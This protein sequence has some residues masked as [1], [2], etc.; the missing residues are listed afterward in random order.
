MPFHHAVLA[1]GLHIVG[2]TLPQA[3]SV[4]FGFFVRTGSRDETPEVNGVSHFLEHMVFKGTE[5]FS[6]ED[7]NR[8]FDDV[9]AQY[10]ASTS[11]EVT[12]FYAAVLP[13]YFAQTFPLQ[14]DILFPSLRTSDFDTEKQ[15]ILEEIGMY[16]DQPSYVAYDA[17]M[18]RH[19]QGHPLGQIILGTKESVGA[20][21][22]E[23]MRAYHAERYRAGNIV[24]A[25][26]GRFDWEEV[27]RLA[28]QSCGHWPAGTPSRVHPPATPQRSTQW[29]A[30]THL[31]Q[32]QIVQLT[33]APS[34]TDEL[35]FAAELLTV[36]VGDDSNSRLYWELV[37][38]GHADSAEISYSD[39]EGAGAFLTYLSGEPDETAANLARIQAICE[40]VNREG[41]T[42][43]ELELAKN[44]VSTR[45]VLRGE[46]P[47]GR[48]SSLGHDWLIRREYRSVEDDLHVLN[49][50]TLADMRRLL[51]RFPLVGTTT[52]GVGPLS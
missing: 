49:A 44:K 22:A 47:M 28:Q 33:P 52:V 48:L 9:G 27:Q 5:Q 4:A 38:P 43:D 39:F 41:V 32:E 11:E 15:V 46:R 12:L 31:Q 19:F 50:L 16:D 1:N 10:N 8:L 35:R 34:A 45:I 20:L 21:T 23:Q 51:D 2:E 36:I 29:I 3:R 17:A 30:R 37:D 25:V 6:A 26:S 14:A 40:A 13:E 18:R 7:V 24:L 42:A